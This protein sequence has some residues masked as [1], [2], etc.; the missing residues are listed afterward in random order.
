MTRDEILARLRERIVAFV[1]SQGARE[2]AEDLAQEVMV[3]LHERYAQVESL[4]ELV[5]LSLQI[6]RFK[7][8]GLRRR[9]VRRGEHQALP[10]DEIQVAG[11][12]PDPIALLERAERHDRLRAAL[13]DLGERCRELFRLKLLG[14][15]FAEI[16][17]ALGAK[18]INT[19]YTWDLRCRQQLRERLERPREERP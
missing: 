17:Q 4:A 18:S 14:K 9:V 2:V 10:V 8:A 3:V 13:L 7:L 15:S 11:H 5:P 1:A 6:V 16:Q 12:E 19:V